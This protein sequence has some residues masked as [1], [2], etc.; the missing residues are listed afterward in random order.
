VDYLL[1]AFVFVAAV[2]DIARHKIYNWN[3]YTGIVVGLIAH[4]VVGGWPGL[5]ESIVGFVVCGLLMLVCFVL[6][7]IG[8]GDVKLIAM[9]GAFLGLEKGIEATLWTFVLGGIVGVACWIWQVGFLNLAKQTLQHLI[10]IVKAKGMIPLSEEE[11]KPLRRQLFLAPAGFAAV[12]V[13]LFVAA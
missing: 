1:L 6:F 8:G 10:L 12:C 2:T 4:L 13:V 9:M 3:T 11:Q 5:E 7:N